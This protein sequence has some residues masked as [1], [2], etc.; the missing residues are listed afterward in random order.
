MNE[1]SPEWIWRVSLI[2]L[3]YLTYLI[4]YY[5]GAVAVDRSSERAERDALE[6]EW[7]RRG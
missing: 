3:C 5:N 7:S 2:L 4:G 1:I 6:E